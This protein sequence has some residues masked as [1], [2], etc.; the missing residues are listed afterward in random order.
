[1]HIK[2]SLNWNTCQIKIYI[3]S[4][5]CSIN[6]NSLFWL[7]KNRKVKKYIARGYILKGNR[8]VR[9]LIILSK[10]MVQF[11]LMLNHT[12]IFCINEWQMINY[13]TI[14]TSLNKVGQCSFLYLIQ[15]WPKD[16]KSFPSTIVQTNVAKQTALL[17]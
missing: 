13:L 2:Y 8:F 11:Q 5:F 7:F 17:W 1:M 12:M 4:I 14:R 15:S 6:Y 3:G 16:R 9:I 10:L